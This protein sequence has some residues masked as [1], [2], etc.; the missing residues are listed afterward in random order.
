MTHHLTLCTE[1]HAQLTLPVTNVRSFTHPLCLLSTRWRRCACAGLLSSRE[2]NGC[3]SVPQPGN[4]CFPLRPGL[5][6]NVSP[7]GGSTVLGLHH[8][9]YCN[10]VQMGP[11]CN[12]LGWVDWTTGGGWRGGVAKGQVMDGIAW[13]GGK[14]PIESQTE[15][16]DHRGCKRSHSQNI[17]LM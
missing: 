4:G 3:V 10:T 2:G 7:R 17:A 11:C 8:R 12:G 1:E 9:D 16:K 14:R 5:G 15:T 13:S 6:L